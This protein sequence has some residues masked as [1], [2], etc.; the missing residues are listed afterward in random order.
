MN[1]NKFKR[2][3]AHKEIAK[4]VE[5]GT[6]DRKLILRYLTTNKMKK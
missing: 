2:I 6:R 4:N 3:K 5:L 1:Y